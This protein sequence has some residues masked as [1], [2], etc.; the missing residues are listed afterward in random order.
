MSGPKLPPETLLEVIT[1]SPFFPRDLAV[2]KRLIL[3]K[4]QLPNHADAETLKSLSLTSRLFVDECRD[5]MFEIFHVRVSP[6]SLQAAVEVLSKPH[7]AKRVRHLTLEGVWVEF[8]GGFRNWRRELEQ[9]G[10]CK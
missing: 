8:D 10:P 2:L 1:C 7:I 6:E 9:I 3:M 5:K 4:F